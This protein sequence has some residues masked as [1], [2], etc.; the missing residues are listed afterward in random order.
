MARRLA[1]KPATAP[2]LLPVDVLEGVLPVES[3]LLIEEPRD[4]AREEAEE[5]REDALE[6]ALESPEEIE[7]MAEEA[8][9]RSIHETQEMK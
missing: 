1:L 7:E 5:R 2:L 8:E 3:R 6:T 4:E 9:G